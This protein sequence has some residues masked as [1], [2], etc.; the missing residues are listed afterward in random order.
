MAKNKQERFARWWQV[1]N[2]RNKA[3]DIIYKSKKRGENDLTEQLLVDTLR[4]ESV[5]VYT[6]S[7]RDNTVREH[8]C[9]REGFC[10]M[11]FRVGDGYG[12][13]GTK[14][15]E[16]VVFGQTL[17][18]REQNRMKAEQLFMEKNLERSRTAEEKAIRLKQ[19]VVM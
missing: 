11:A 18:L 4:G 6:Y 3:L 2:E 17:W 15:D 10:D 9:V 14:S 16:G 8:H 5:Y 1:H 19:R 12:F 7:S 13:T